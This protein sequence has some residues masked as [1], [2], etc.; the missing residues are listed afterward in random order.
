M[1]SGNLIYVLVVLAVIVFNIIKSKA[2]QQEEVRDYTDNFPEKE[3]WRDERTVIVKEEVKNPYTSTFNEHHEIQKKK[4]IKKTP[5]AQQNDKK[6]SSYHAIEEDKD[7]SFK[8]V[9]DA[10]RAFI[11]SEIWNRKY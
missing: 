6:T 8:D 1:D 11:Y 2:K 5:V 7:I 10:R 3:E 4:D 9:E